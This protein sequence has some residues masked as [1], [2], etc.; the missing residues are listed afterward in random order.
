MLN[1][2]SHL[3]IKRYP[4]PSG[5]SDNISLGWDYHRSQTE[6]AGTGKKT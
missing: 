3:S 4:F 2:N 6:A 1:K 5:H